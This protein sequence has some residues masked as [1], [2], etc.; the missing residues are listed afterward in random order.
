MAQVVTRIP[1]ELANAVDQ[2]VEDGF[3]ASRS[4]AVR[5]ALSELVDRHRRHKVGQAIVDGYE[6]IPQTDADNMWSD[7]ATI[8]MIL[9]EPW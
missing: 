4:E 9:E 3:V 2:L 1:E 8:D 5:Q 7:R 6:K